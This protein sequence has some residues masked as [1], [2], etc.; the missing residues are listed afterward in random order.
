MS[1]NVN[2]CPEEH[3]VG[4]LA[5]KVL[6]FVERQPSH[7]G[8][9]PGHDGPA[10]GKQDEAAVEGQDEGGASGDPDGEVEDV[11]GSQVG[12]G[13]LPPPERVSDGRR[14]LQGR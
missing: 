1:G 12:V 10:H 9:K 14:R 6:C 13:G 4:D 11:Q 5:V 8:A 3:R 2:D 7:L